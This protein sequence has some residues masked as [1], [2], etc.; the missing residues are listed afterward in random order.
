MIVKNSKEG[1]FI[2]DFTDN[3]LAILCRKSI[4]SDVDVRSIIEIE[5]RRVLKPIL[6]HNNKG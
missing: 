5:L 6:D 3:E 2:L 4:M 1:D